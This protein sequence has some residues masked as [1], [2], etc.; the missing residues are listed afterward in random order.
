MPAIVGSDRVV[1]TD[2]SGDTLRVMTDTAQIRALELFANGRTDRWER[3][4]DGLGAPLVNATFYAGS[5]VTAEFRAG[6]DFL[7][8]NLPGG[9]AIRAATAAEVNAFVGLLG[10]T[11][12]VLKPRP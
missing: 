4:W 12:D 1:I 9:S 5:S 11:P 6:R 8:A 7:F 2:F 3:P 10:V